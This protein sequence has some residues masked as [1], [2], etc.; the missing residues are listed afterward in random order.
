MMHEEDGFFPPFMAPE[1]TPLI[2]KC[3]VFEV[4]Q[5]R[6]AYSQPLQNTGKHKICTALDRQK[7]GIVPAVSYTKPQVSKQRGGQIVTV[8][9]VPILP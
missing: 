7:C 1:A 3:F 4:S 5:N 6:G 2:T 8:V 9:A